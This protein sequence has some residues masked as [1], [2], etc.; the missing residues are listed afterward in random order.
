MLASLFHILRVLRAILRNLHFVAAKMVKMEGFSVR[1]AGAY[2]LPCHV[3]ALAPYP[4][5]RG[6]A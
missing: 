4:A 1:Q 3:L 6:F 2:A 5:N